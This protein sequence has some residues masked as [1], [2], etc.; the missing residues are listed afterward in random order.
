MRECVSNCI[1]QRKLPECD[2]SAAGK[3]KAFFECKSKHRT[4]YRNC[5]TECQQSQNRI[6]WLIGHNEE[7]LCEA[8][9]LDRA[10]KLIGK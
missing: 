6:E 8:E 9:A 4:Q 3:E 2:R 1:E 5:E 10:N 7:G